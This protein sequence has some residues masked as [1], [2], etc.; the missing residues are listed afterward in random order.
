V[1]NP[2]GGATSVGSGA[3]GR[4]GESGRAREGGQAAAGSDRGAFLPAA[5]AQHYPSSPAEAAAA[6]FQYGGAR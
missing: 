2:G 4:H 3:G 1:L 6:P 5:A